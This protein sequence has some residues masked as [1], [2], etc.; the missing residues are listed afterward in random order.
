M[1]GRGR[2]RETREVLGRE[3]GSLQQVAGDG[4]AWRPRMAEGP[5]VPRKP[6]N[7]GG[8]KG[9][10]LRI[11]AGSGEG[12]RLVNL[13]TPIGVQKLQSALH[14]KCIIHEFYIHNY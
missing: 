13:S 14:A 9:P 8:G 2:A 7:A 6:G 12:G 11:N 4:G 3:G 5:V 10:W 1:C